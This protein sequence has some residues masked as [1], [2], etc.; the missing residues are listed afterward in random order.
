MASRTVDAPTDAER[1]LE[2]AVATLWA[3]FDNVVTLCMG[4]VDLIAD[5][6][7]LRRVDPVKLRE[8]TAAK[9]CTSIESRNAVLAPLGIDA[10]EA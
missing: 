8:A 1:D 2:Q 7:L 6:D 4:L 3:E 5:K 10:E 9:L